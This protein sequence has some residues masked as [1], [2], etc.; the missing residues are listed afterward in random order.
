MDKS[1]HLA[2]GVSPK[3]S[4]RLGDI[5]PVLNISRPYILQYLVNVVQ[6]K[7]EMI[8]LTN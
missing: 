6:T 2:D 1:A 3:S 8:L 7:R 5:M 4:T